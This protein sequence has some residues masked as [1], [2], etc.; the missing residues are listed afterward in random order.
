M[1]YAGTGAD[2]LAFFADNYYHNVSII[3][4]LNYLKSQRAM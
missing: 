3:Q 2:D 4:G 1:S